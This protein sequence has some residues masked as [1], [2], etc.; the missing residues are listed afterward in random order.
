[1]IKEL[2]FAGCMPQAEVFQQYIEEDGVPFDSSDLPVY[3][4]ETAAF[5]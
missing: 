4:M 3:D 1:M 5:S 2:G